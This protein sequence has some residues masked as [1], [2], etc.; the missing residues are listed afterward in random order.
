M[1]PIDRPWKGPPEGV[2][3]RGE[4]PQQAMEPSTRRAQASLEFTSSST[5]S[6]PDGRSAISPEVA[7]G[8]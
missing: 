3:S 5:K 4:G 2:Q 7:A 1:A 6:S 8:P